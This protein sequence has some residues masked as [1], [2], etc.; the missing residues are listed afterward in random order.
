MSIVVRLRAWAIAA[1]AAAVIMGAGFAAR[2]GTSPRDL[3]ALKK[4]S[5]IYIAT[6]RKDGNQ[7]KAAPVWFTLASDDRILI[8][9]GPQTWKA[10]RIRRGSPAIVWIGAADG[11][12]FIGK[13]EIVSEPAVQNQIITDYPRKYLLARV[14]FAR[15]TAEKFLAGKIVAIRITPLKDLPE[16]FKSDPGTPAPKP[17]AQPQ[18]TPAQT[19]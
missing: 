2:A 5:L 12:A 11:P 17:P 10:K 13:A 6:F 7:S 18:A 4:A 9:T 19:K 14:G 16:G 8:E 15:P 1:L 3:A